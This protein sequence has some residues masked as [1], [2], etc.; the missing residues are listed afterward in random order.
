MGTERY[1]CTAAKRFE[2]FGA[3]PVEK[4]NIIGLIFYSIFIS[5]LEKYLPSKGLHL[6]SWERESYK[7]ECEIV[8][9]A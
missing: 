5:D 8:T 3:R 1:I 6:T 4:Y 2:S 9:K 7:L